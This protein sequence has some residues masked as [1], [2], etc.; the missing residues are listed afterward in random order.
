MNTFNLKDQTYQGG[1][2]AEVK[3]MTGSTVTGRGPEL[4]RSG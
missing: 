3:E 1:V 2:N 4:L